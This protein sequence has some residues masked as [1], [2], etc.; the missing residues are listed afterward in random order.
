[1]KIILPN[2]R[3]SAPIM[4][5]DRVL[6]RTIMKILN[7]FTVLPR[8]V[9][10]GA[11][12]LLATS[13][14]LAA[15][16]PKSMVALLKAKGYSVDELK[17]G[18]K[19]QVVPKEWVEKAK[20]EQGALLYSGVDDPK[21]MQ[22]YL[23]VFN[24]RYPF[25]KVQYT[26]GVGAGR[27]VKPL[28]AWKAGS[29]TTEVVT[30]FESS[31]KDYLDA[32]AL[33]P[34]NDLPAWSGIPDMYKDQKGRWAGLN[35]ANWCM[36]YSTERVK[37]SELPK[38]WMD[39][40]K[41]NSPL[42]GG[43]VG[44]ANRAHLWL[45]M[46]WGEMGPDKVKNEFL[47]AFFNNLKPQLR[48]EGIN[49]MMKLI[50]IGEIDVA[51]PIAEYRAKIQNDKGAKLGF[52]CP[53][54]VPQYFTGFGLFRKS[55]HEYSGKLFVNWMLSKEGQLARLAA[56]GTAPSHKDLQKAKFIPFGEE[57]VGKKVGLR[58]VHLLVDELPKL[59]KVWNPAWQNAGGPKGR[60]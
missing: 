15:D 44:V 55:P 49:A 26:R 2:I 20:K 13:L 59:Y 9:V 46:L 53:D 60:N 35:L 34:I 17:G 45:L 4:D 41:P 39:F 6:G 38:T 48:K 7:G 30:A 50:A 36:A 43:R 27:A 29:P 57:I 16:T 32:N 10:V 14:G 3:R 47:P 18:E 8:A 51:L 12:L 25:I 24:E 22:K 54:I 56:I 40:V 11:A 42:K 31:M 52:H 23:A 21:L 37:K 58:T 28:I 33:E 5:A 1:M 19:E